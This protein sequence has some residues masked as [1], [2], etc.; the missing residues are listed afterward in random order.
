MFLKWKHRGK[1][2]GHGCADG[3]KQSAYIT[4]E[5]AAS[6]TVATESVFLTAIIN[7]LEGHDVAVVD[8]PGAF[9][10]ADMDELVHVRFTGKMVDQLLEID[11]QM[12]GPCVVMEGKEKVMYVEL[13]KALYGTVRAARLLW[14]KLTAKL[15]EWGFTPNPYDP[16]V[17]N[18]VSN[19]R[20]PG[21]WMI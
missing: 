11:S 8:V 2:K 15:R 16:C 6:P 20:L 17:M 5:D 10:Q 14:E 19:S 4:C 3:R 7:A 12:Y 18:K 13:L 1:I 9:M 21:M